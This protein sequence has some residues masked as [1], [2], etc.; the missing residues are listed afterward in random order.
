MSSLARSLSTKTFPLKD[1]KMPKSGWS[2]LFQAVW[3]RGRF[4]WEIRPSW[5]SI[6]NPKHT[7]RRHYSKLRTWKIY[8][9]SKS[10]GWRTH[11][12]QN[13]M[14]TKC[15]SMPNCPIT[16]KDPGESILDNFLRSV[17]CNDV[18]CNSQFCDTAK[19]ILMRT[20]CENLVWR[21]S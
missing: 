15:I 12:T 13:F 5:P 16:N 9:K 11:F 3:H 8:R 14:S 18:L 17:Q 1:I 4:I 2:N 10:R 21:R 6:L 19:K 20:Q 7:C